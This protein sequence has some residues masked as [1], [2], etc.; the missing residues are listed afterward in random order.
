MDAIGAI[1]GERPLTTEEIAKRAFE[2]A[3]NPR[4]N[5][6]KEILDAAESYE[7]TPPLLGIFNDVARHKLRE[8]EVHAWATAGFSFIVNDA[9]H[10]QWEGWYGREQNAVE[11]RHGLLPLQ[12][13]HREASSSHGDAF[14]LGARATMRPYATTLREAEEYYRSIR[15]PNPGSAT[16]FDRGGYPVRMG[17]RS[18]TFTPDSI[19]EAETETQG[20][21]QF[22]TAEL[23]LYASVRD[24][25]LD[26]MGEQGRNRACGFVGPFDA[27]L[28]EGAI[29]EMEEAIG[30]LFQAAA[31]RGVHMGRVIGSGSM[32]DPS[33]IENAMVEAIDQGCRLICVHR[34]TSDLPLHGAMAISEPFFRAA[35]RCG[36]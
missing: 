36:F 32:E 14:Q 27:I 6:L 11:A 33:D 4:R 1:G 30:R 21:L 8:D 12:R 15:F 34:F 13:L 35:K 17:D 20:W 5:P 25:V 18:M 16:P 9:E 22:E 26:L 28:R 7:R 2:H 3:I 31:R 29:P 10:L 19:R 23:I 24:R